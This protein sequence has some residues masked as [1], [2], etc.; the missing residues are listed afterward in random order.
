MTTEQYRVL[1]DLNGKPNMDLQLGVTAEKENAL[2][3][4]ERLKKNPNI[5]NIHIER[6][7]ATYTEWEE[8]K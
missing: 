7:I 5:S 8:T 3:A 2:K 6:R 1:Y 4:I